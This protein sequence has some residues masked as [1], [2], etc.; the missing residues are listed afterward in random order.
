MFGDPPLVFFCHAVMLPN[1]LF[2]FKYNHQLSKD[3]VMES[4]KRVKID[5]KGTIKQNLMNVFDY[6][7]DSEGIGNVNSLSNDMAEFVRRFKLLALGQCG[8][9]PNELQKLDV[10]KISVRQA[11]SA[12]YSRDRCTFKSGWTTKDRSATVVDNQELVQ[13]F[14][15]FLERDDNTTQGKVLSRTI[16]LYAINV[17][18]KIK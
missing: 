5:V 12:G 3:V 13:H 4:P 14:R 11:E 9:F 17:Y 16:I 18:Y 15:T 7:L 8:S 1:F 6:F 10:V 2:I